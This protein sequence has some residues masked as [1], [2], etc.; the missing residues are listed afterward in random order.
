MSGRLFS[1]L[2][3][4]LAALMIASSDSLARPSGEHTSTPGFFV[5]TSCACFLPSRFL[6]SA[7]VPLIFV[8]ELSCGCQ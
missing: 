3:T 8:G 1:T 6:S 5:M 2:S 4:K 7:Y